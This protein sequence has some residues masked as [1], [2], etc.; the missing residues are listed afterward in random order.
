LLFHDA[1][2]PDMDAYLICY[3]IACSFAH[4]FGRFVIPMIFSYHLELIGK[5][6]F[7][8]WSSCKT[9]R[10]ELLFR[11]CGFLEFLDFSSFH[12]DHERYIT[13]TFFS[14]FTI[15][16]LFTNHVNKSFLT[17]FCGSFALFRTKQASYPRD[18][19]VLQGVQEIFDRIV[20]KETRAE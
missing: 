15:H 5:V 3:L 1:I 7:E 17:Y 18:R 14:K 13:S 6:E 19:P 20:C 12:P 16:G 9:H 4:P 8:T 2:R 11:F 10:V